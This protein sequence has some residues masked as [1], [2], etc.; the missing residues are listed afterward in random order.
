[1]KRRKALER[2]VDLARGEHERDLLRQQAASH[3]RKRPR[4]RVVQPVRVVDTSQERTLL[5]RLGQQAEDRQSNQERIR[6]GVGGVRNQSERDAKRVV[7]GLRETVQKVQERG[8]QLLN[9]RERELHLRFG[10]G[11]PRDP[12]PPR[13]LDRVLEQRRLADARFAMHHPHAAT[14]AAHAVQ[15]PVEHLPLAFPADQPPS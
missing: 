7:L 9:R 11:R 10:P 5:G 6:R 2:V 14:P 13:S 8:T 15:Q 4:R 12:K 3:E 1:M